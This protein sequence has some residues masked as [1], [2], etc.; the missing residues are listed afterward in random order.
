MKERIHLW[1]TSPPPHIGWW[2]ASR[3]KSAEEWRWW[4]GVTWSLGVRN[5]RTSFDVLAGAQCA[6][7]GAVSDIMWT[8][9]YPEGA[10]VPRVDPSLPA[11]RGIVECIN[12]TVKDG[13]SAFWARKAWGYYNVRYVPMSKE[14]KDDWAKFAVTAIAM[15]T[16]KELAETNASLREDTVTSEEEEAWVAPTKPFDVK[17][18]TPEVPP[19]YVPS[20]RQRLSDSV[21]AGDADF[22]GAMKRNT[23]VRNIR[24]YRETD[25]GHARGAHMQLRRGAASTGQAPAPVTPAARELSSF[26]T[27]E[28]MKE[29]FRRF[30]DK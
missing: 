28:L 11:N 25:T 18:H 14:F 9:Y 4:D 24:N 27:F 30:N 26:N 13:D 16:S 29:L 19:Q 2:N 5:T 21:R 8:D 6:V 7:I 15:P 12:M 20:S 1:K 3:F 23:D 22:Q 10:R 17:F